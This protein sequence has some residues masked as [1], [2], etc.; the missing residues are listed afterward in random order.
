MTNQRLNPPS[1]RTRLHV[2]AHVWLDVLGYVLVFATVA[3]A[4]G[5]VVGFVTG[6]GLLR[7]KG[8]LFVFGFLV[9]AYATFRL[10][11][12]AP[13]S[14]GAGRPDGGKPGAARGSISEAGSDSR[15]EAIVRVLPPARWARPPPERQISTA[16]KLFIGSLSVLL[17]SYLMEAI[18]G[19]T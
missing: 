13:G 14:P 4:L 7:A 5:V 12:S 6:G 11:P 17:T 19:V 3:T 8:F 2:A 18:F 10:W 9:M 16:T 1:I 15:F